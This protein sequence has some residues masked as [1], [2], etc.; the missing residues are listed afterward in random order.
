MC[1][2]SV[3][4]ASAAL[5]TAE[6]CLVRFICTTGSHIQQPIR[7]LPR[8]CCADFRKC[9]PVCNILLPLLLAMV[10]CRGRNENPEGHRH[11]HT[12]LCG[13]T[14]ECMN[15]PVKKKMKKREKMT[16]K[17]TLPAQAVQDKLTVSIALHANI[18]TGTRTRHTTNRTSHMYM[19]A[20][21]HARVRARE[22]QRNRRH[23]GH[24]TSSERRQLLVR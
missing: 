17:C 2:H 15:A 4:M 16:Q 3:P 7:L 20:Q 11:S 10:C 8:D 1:S 22:S 18:H 12:L 6:Q 23:A 21:T 19:H 14:D 9:N 24:N 13:R 5:P